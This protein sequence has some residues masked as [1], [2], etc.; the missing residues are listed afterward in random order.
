VRLRLIRNRCGLCGGMRGSG[1]WGVVEQSGDLGRSITMSSRLHEGIIAF[2][3]GR[4]EKGGGFFEAGGI[5]GPGRRVGYLNK[6]GGR[7]S[8]F[9]KGKCLGAE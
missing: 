5:T 9:A 1:G 6:S 7:P 8:A 2:R 3:L 4:E